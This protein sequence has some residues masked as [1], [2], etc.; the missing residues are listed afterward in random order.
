MVDEMAEV[1]SFPGVTAPELPADHQPQPEIVERLREL[2]RR[3]EAGDVRAI[4]YCYVNAECAPCE[5]QVIP[6]E[7][8]RTVDYTLG[9]AAAALFHRFFAIQVDGSL[10]TA[11]FPPAEPA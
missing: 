9:F 4:A 7:V 8:S 1:H 10:N 5:G 3:A 2:L 6:N 11:P